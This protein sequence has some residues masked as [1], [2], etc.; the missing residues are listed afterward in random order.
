[1]DAVE[2][3]KIAAH[4]VNTFLAGRPRLQQADREDLRQD[5]LA[6]M[7]RAMKFH[8]PAILPMRTYLHV[9]GRRAVSL[10]YARLMKPRRHERQTLP[11]FADQAVVDRPHLDDREE[12][13]LLLSCLTPA[14]RAAVEACL[15]GGQNTREY[16][17][18]RGRKRATDRELV[19]LAKIDMWRFA[20][21][22]HRIV[23]RR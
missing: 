6:H 18:S 20:V 19:R 23:A 15:L 10:Y 7:L 12:V 11:E 9:V 5:V 22:R 2:L 17:A 13:G 8:D 3:M 16:S 14:R 1:M 21:S 4:R